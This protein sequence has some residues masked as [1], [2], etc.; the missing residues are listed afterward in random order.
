MKN[1]NVRKAHAFG[2]VPVVTNYSVHHSGASHAHD[3]ILNVYFGS[4]LFRFSGEAVHRMVRGTLSA[5]LFEPILLWILNLMEAYKYK[6][7]DIV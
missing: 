1:V 4:Q 3:E 2:D 6:S 5:S 7:R